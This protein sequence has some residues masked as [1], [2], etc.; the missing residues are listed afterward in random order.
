MTGPWLRPLAVL[1]LA[2]LVL[3]ACS[4]S[5]GG[6]ASQR[7]ASNAPSAAASSAE[8]PHDGATPSAAASADASAAT[9]GPPPLTSDPLHALVL[10]DVRSGEEFT[11]GQLAAEEPVLLETMAIWCTNCRAQQRNVV[12]AHGL[13]EFHSISLDV[14]PNEYPNDLA[15]YADRE[16]FDWRFA[17]ANADLVGQLRDRFGTAVAVPPGM[18]KILFRTDGSVEFVGLGELLSPEQIAATVSG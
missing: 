17:T 8:T 2:S 16:G 3:A 7:A 10:T 6:G 15:D 11:I 4:A 14:D 5:A 18:P 13:A 9:S 12:D 1:A